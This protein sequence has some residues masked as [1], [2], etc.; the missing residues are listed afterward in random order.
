MLSVNKIVRN[1]LHEARLIIYFESPNENSFRKAEGMHCFF[2]QSYLM[3][4]VL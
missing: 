4:L 2:F 3:H 1:F